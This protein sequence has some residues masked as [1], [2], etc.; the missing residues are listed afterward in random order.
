ML[1]VAMTKDQDSQSGQQ[2]F[3][4]RNMENSKIQ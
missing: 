3:I 1:K 2:F 4:F